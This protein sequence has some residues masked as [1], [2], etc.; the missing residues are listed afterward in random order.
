MDAP[1]HVWCDGRLLPSAG[2]HLSAFDRAFQLGDG[3]FETL[4]AV[5]GSPVELA[6]HA[7]RLVRSAV[8]LSIPLPLG[9]SDADGVEVM[10]ASAI[11]EVLAAE[12]L[13]APTGD[14]AIRVTLSRGAPAV[15][16]LLVPEG[17]TPT[18]VVQA[19]PTVPAAAAHLERGLHLV[20]SSVRRDPAH[21]LTALKTTSRAETIFARLEAK[22]AGADDA[23]LLTL[24]GLASESTTANLFIVRGDE[25]AT[26]ALDCAILP[27]TTRDWLL[28]W[29]PGVGLQPAET[30]LRPHDVEQAD[31]AFLCSSVAGVLPVTRLG[32]VP[33]GDG[34][35]GRWSRRARAEREA[36]V[37]ALA[38]ADR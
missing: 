5:A 27:G 13:D 28:A 3:V 32:D 38:G 22:A 33:I 7:R 15:R 36:H 10:L 21:P 2:P 6:A 17:T 31:E 16:G 37:R 29:A 24:D 19:W 18:L 34:L 14:A 1:G 25:L 26:P 4:R 11:A 12:G 8:G 9:A 30:W 35:P 23:L 20:V